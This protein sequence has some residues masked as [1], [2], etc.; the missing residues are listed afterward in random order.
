MGKENILMCAKKFELTSIENVSK[1]LAQ[2]PPN[3]LVY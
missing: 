3:I 1:A 2:E